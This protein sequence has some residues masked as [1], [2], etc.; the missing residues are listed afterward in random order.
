MRIMLA[1]AT[2]CLTMVSPAQSWAQAGDSS[3][4]RYPDR[5]IRLITPSA[6]GGGADILSRVIAQKMTESF[7]QQVVVDNRPAATGVIGTDIVAKSIPNG[8]TL[9]MAY[10]AHAVNVSLFSKLPFDAIK[11]FSAVTL[12]ASAP[13]I[14]V[15]NPAV[16]MR[17]VKDLIAQ[18]RSKPGQLNYASAGNGTSPH[19]AMELF[20]SMAKVNITGVPYIGGPATIVATL[21]GETPMTFGLVAITLPHLKSGKLIGLAVTSSQ[22]MKLT[23]DLPTVAEAALPGYEAVAWFGVIAPAHTPAA[24]ITKLDQELKRIMQQPDVQE[25]LATLGYEII[26]PA[27][28]QK[29]AAYIEAEI[30]KWA[31]VIKDAGIRAD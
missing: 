24:I 10:S 8:Y 7:G 2:T 20:K 6:P 23:P 12:C 18:A 26:P 21:S 1:L 15:V 14:L 28:P 4:Q 9:L 29:F 22:R 13:Y 27:T 30:P 31:K 3:A 25:R 5:P 16:Q 11:D 19:L 17:S